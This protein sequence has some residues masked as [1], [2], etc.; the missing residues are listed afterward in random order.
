MSFSQN[1]FAMSTSVGTRLW[2]T[3]VITAR[4]YSASPSDTLTPGEFVC[5]AST[6]NGGVTQVIKGS[7]LTS[8]YIGIALVNVLKGSWSVGDELEVAVFGTAAYAA[9]ASAITCGD[10]LQYDYTTTYVATQ[11]GQ[12]TIVAQALENAVNAG[13]LIRVVVMP[14]AAGSDTGPTGAQGS[15]G[16]QGKQGNQGNQGNQAP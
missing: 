16:Y 6:T 2:G 15:Q 1:Q 11:V 4:F 5:L 14:P 7:G 12:N 13:D 3:N 10:F 8:R 9:A